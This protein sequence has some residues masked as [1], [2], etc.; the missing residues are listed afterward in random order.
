M[1]SINSH[2]FSIASLTSPSRKCSGSVMETPVSKRHKV[3]TEVSPQSTDS[4]LSRIS[5]SRLSSTDGSRSCSPVDIMKTVPN[6]EVLK[7]A[8]SILDPL[9]SLRQHLS[10]HG[11]KRSVSPGAQSDDSGRSSPQVESETLSRKGSPHVE[12]RSLSRKRSHDEFDNE[13]TT[14]VNIEPSGDGKPPH[15]Y[16][17]LISMA[18]LNHPERRM[19]LSD[20]YQWIMDSFPYYNNEERAWRN[21]IRH[22][23]S[24]NECFIKAGRAENGKGN[25]WSIHPSCIEDFSRGDYRRRQA[26]RRART[27]AG[28][29]ETNLM[30]PMPPV[31]SVPPLPPPSVNPGTSGISPAVSAATALNY[32]ANVGYV[33]MTSTPL[34]SAFH[35]YLANLHGL[36]QYF[37][38]PA[39]SLLPPGHPAAANLPVPAALHP[40]HRAAAAAAALNA[41]AAAVQHHSL[42]PVKT[43]QS[44]SP[45]SSPGAQQAA[46]AFHLSLL[47]NR[48]STSPGRYPHLPP[49]HPHA[50]W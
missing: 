6:A 17:A 28:Q 34:S 19:V 49:G 22:N 32:H 11:Y 30:P 39:A 40:V 48:L 42:S 8:G 13:H 27:T 21:S 5:P 14:P 1:D 20:I 23:L 33:P 7:R 16:I 50:N 4:G 10:S 44:S 36:N 31:L 41:A 43:E 46:A 37:P 47:Q 26:R 15:S 24:L 12:P 3:D 2:P 45:P 38:Q 35:P 29:V 18:I 25:Y 9:A